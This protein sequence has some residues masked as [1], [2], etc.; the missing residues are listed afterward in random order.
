M[1]T[2]YEVQEYTLFDGWINTWTD[3]NA[4]PSY[5]ETKENAQSQLDWFLNECLLEV[6]AGNMED[7]PSREDFRIVAV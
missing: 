5:F 1:T 7:V 2:L 6:D 4:K 3:E